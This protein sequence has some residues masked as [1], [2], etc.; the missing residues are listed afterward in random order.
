MSG[1]LLRRPLPPLKKE[2]KSGKS[3][4]ITDKYKAKLQHY[5]E[6]NKKRPYCHSFDIFEDGDRNLMKP[7][8]PQPFF[9]TKW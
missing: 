8:G 3:N 5:E 7:L 9:S 4:T 1:Y 2:S 6:I